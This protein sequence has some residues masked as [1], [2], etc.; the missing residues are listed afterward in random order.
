MAGGEAADSDEMLV[1]A[2]IC[3]IRETRRASTSTLQRRLR[4]GFT[5]AGR[6]MDILEERGIIGPS[7]GAQ[8]RDILVD[9]NSE[10]NE[11]GEPITGGAEEEATLAGDDDMIDDDLDD[12]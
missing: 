12:V 11:S 2:A 3:L 1:R 4:I 9:L 6:I 5:R 7:Q 10:F 8:A